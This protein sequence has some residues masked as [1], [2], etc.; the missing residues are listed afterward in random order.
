[1]V[2][3]LN[4]INQLLLL[5]VTICYYGLSTNKH[6]SGVTSLRGRCGMQ[7]WGLANDGHD[8]IVDF[9]SEMVTRIVNPLPPILNPGPPQ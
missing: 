8:V 1:M 9:G 5:Y 6:N 3:I 2:D 7:N 4:Y